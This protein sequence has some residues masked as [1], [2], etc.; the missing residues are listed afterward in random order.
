MTP[1]LRAYTAE[2]VVVVREHHGC[3]LT[4]QKTARP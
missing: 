4:V 3:W 2:A 1:P